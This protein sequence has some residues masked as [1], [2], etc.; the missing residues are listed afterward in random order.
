MNTL[1][2]LR[3]SLVQRRLTILM[4]IFTI[5]ISNLKQMVNYLLVLGLSMLNL[6]LVLCLILRAKAIALEFKLSLNLLALNGLLQVM[7]TWN[8]FRYFMPR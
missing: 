1:I 6:A 4:M 5:K 7:Q 3:Q 8:L 2:K